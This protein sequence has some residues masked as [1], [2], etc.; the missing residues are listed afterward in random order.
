MTKQAV[1]QRSIKYLK[2]NPTVTG[3]QSTKGDRLQVAKAQ[4][5]SQK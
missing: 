4:N 2:M 5:S 3:V 1:V